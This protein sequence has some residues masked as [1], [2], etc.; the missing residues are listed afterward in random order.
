MCYLAQVLVGRQGKA[1]VFFND[2]ILMDVQR[3]FKQELKGP[4]SLTRRSAQQNVNTS[5]QEIYRLCF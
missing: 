4:V 2:L 5:A 1:N 3:T